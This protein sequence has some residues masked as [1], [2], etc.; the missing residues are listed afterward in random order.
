MYVE[1]AA[2]T[3]FVRKMLIWSWLTGGYQTWEKIW[4]HFRTLKMDSFCLSV[5]L[6]TNGRYS[7]FD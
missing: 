7:E 6:K 2:E 4:E 5:V 3:T 1:K